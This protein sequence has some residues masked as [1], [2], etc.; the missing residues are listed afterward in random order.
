MCRPSWK[1]AGIKLEGS[2][3]T[4]R[5]EKRLVETYTSIKPSRRLADRRLQHDGRLPSEWR[6]AV[7]CSEASQAARFPMAVLRHELPLWLPKRMVSS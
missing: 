7:R 4:I 5:H 1:D 2:G 6:K 3:P